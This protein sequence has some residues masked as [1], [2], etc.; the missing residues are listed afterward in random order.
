MTIENITLSLLENALDFIIRGL[1]ELYDNSEYEERFITPIS[2]PQKDY[3][4][5]ILHLYAG[6]ILLLKE[7]LYRDT[8]SLIYTNGEK[9]VNYKQATE[10]LKNLDNME[11]QVVFNERDKSIIKDIQDYRNVFEHYKIDN[12]DT[13]KLKEVIIDFIDVINRF[14]NQ[15]LEINIT[16]PPLNITHEM[17]VKILSIKPIYDR[18]IEDSKR[19]IQALGEEK[20]KNFKKVRLRVLRDIKKANEIYVYETGDD[21][22][23]FGNCP[24]CNEKELIFEGEFAGVCTNKR[25]YEYTSLTHCDKCGAITIGYD[26]EETWC[27]YCCE[28]LR[29]LIENDKT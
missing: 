25:C 1:D 12:V 16:S 7:K 4:Y 23:I 18:M 19:E 27:E 15:H 8:P 13:L 5:G 10:R 20:V 14:L 17:R 24:K 26:W 22:D 11:N 3:K 6:F 28:Y 29:E 21:H 2:Q 9:T